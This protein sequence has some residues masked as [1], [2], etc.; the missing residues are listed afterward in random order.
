MDWKCWQIRIEYL[1]GIA[2]IGCITP[3]ASLLR[4]CTHL[5]IQNVVRAHQSTDNSNSI[6]IRTYS[7]TSHKVYAVWYR[8]NLSDIFGN[9]II[10]YDMNFSLCILNRFSFTVDCIRVQRLAGISFGSY[11]LFLSDRKFILFCIFFVCFS[12]RIFSS[13]L[14]PSFSVFSSISLYLCASCLP[15][16]VPPNPFNIHA[17][18]V[19]TAVELA[20]P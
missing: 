7:N 4:C 8:T 15:F 3:K 14:S 12:L 18:R 5:T 9:Y 10:G 19:Y 16:I 6:S 20:K 2:E 11:L 1:H 13:P 17:S